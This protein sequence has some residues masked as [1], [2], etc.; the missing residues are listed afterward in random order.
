MYMAVQKKH[1]MRAISFS[2]Q[3]CEKE[4]RVSGVFAGATLTEP[5]NLPFSTTISKK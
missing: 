1:R 4:G 2:R 3:R 5:A